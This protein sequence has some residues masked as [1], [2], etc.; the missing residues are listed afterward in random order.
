MTFEEWWSKTGAAE[1]LLMGQKYAAQVSWNFAEKV[2][3]EA[4]ARACDVQVRESDPAQFVALTIVDGLRSEFAKKISAPNVE[5]LAH[6]QK[7]HA[8][9]LAKALA[10]GLISKAEVP[11]AQDLITQNAASFTALCAARAPTKE[12]K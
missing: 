11:W 9:L 3:R 1:T 4:C 7:A 12:T 5:V 8:A 6:N 2:E 10:D